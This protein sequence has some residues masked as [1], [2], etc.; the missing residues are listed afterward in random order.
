[1]TKVYEVR[2]NGRYELRVE[3]TLAGRIVLVR[4][5]PDRTWVAVGNPGRSDGH[6]VTVFDAVMA[7][8]REI[9]R[10]HPGAITLD[11]V[12]R[13]GACDELHAIDMAEKLRLLEVTA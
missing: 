12:C 11:Y 3:R 2:A 9:P 8:R 6:W 10:N 5:Y 1:M 13:C 4:R 7:A